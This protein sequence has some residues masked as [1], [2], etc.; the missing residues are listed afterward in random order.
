MTQHATPTADLAAI[1]AE[2]S[3]AKPS[4]TTMNLIV[5]IDSELKQLR[6]QVENA[7]DVLNTGEDAVRERRAQLAD[8]ERIL[9]ASADALENLIGDV[10]LA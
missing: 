10:A 7:L 9:E 2:L 1:H 3:R 5:W 6:I 4:M 8:W